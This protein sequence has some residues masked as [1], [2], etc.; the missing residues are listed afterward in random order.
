MGRRGRNN[1]RKKK[2]G[3]GGY[4]RIQNLSSVEVEVKTVEGRNVDDMGMDKITGLIGPGEQLPKEGQNP[5]D[6]EDD[7]DD[8]DDAYQYIEGDVRN[9][10][11]KDG[12]FHLEAHPKDGSTGN[13]QLTLVVD[14]N[15]WKSKDETPD[16]YDKC[17]VKLVA[18]VDEED[19]DNWKIELRIYDNYNPCKWMEEYG[20]KHNLGSKRFCDVGIPGTHD[21]GTYKFDKD[22]GASP[23]SGLT[24]KLEDILD[25]GRLLGKLNDF[26]LKNIFERLCQCQDLSIKEQLQLGVRYFDL[27]VAHHAESD[28]YMTCH[29]VYC[30]D[31]KEILTELNDFLTTN[32]KEVVVL[33][34]KKL[35]NMQEEQYQ[36]LSDMVVEVL[37]DKI[38]HRSKVTQK[39]TIQEYWDNGYQLAILYQRRK[40]LSDDRKDQFWN[41]GYI[42][43]PWP[44]AGDNSEL[45]D[46]LKGYV[47]KH[48]E[49][50]F[51]V[52]QGLLT[53]DVELIKK[54]I[55]ES[56]GLS[57]KQ[58]SDKCKGC[59]VDWVEE[60]WKSTNRLNIVIVDFFENC[61]I[62]PAIINYNRP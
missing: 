45:Y 43:S 8:D 49:D 4:I 36:A 35:F 11:Q 33:E 3:E 48:N 21:S 12:F 27:R 54:E 31:M 44:N 50:D 13:S 56:G 20:E 14:R 61:S 9:R 34:F 15:S 37:G 5:F 29:G 2:G 41:M 7:G 51:F 1:R 47:D 17:S 57:I 55:L 39:S 10:F 30:V 28:S 60:E 40:T 38:A 23:E 52:I 25:H 46:K 53:P 42:E 6:K 18:D 19:D 32:S 26:I 59:I 58:I 16:D 62:I 22:K 24:T